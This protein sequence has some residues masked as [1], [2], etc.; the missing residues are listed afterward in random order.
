M[1]EVKSPATDGTQPSRGTGRDVA[2]FLL[3][4]ALAVVAFTGLPTGDAPVD[5]YGGR[6]DRIESTAPEARTNP[7]LS[8]PP[9]RAQR[10]RPARVSGAPVALEPATRT[11]TPC[12]AAVT[13]GAQP[14]NGKELLQHDRSG[15]GKLHI[16]NG[17]NYPGVGVLID[18]STRRPFRA[19]YVHASSTATMLRVNPG[20][21]RLQFALG[22]TWLE[23]EGRF[24]RTTGV[25]ELERPLE[26]AEV[27]R[28]DGILYDVIEVTFHK[29]EGGNAPT[30]DLPLEA[31]ALTLMG[32]DDG[33]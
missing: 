22:Q 11:P 1:E 33:E 19:M 23:G 20:T 28:P 5:A 9:V 21:Y 30:R 12:E 15:L 16:K 2:N 10:E 3:V 7:P 27:S 26:F 13:A 18:T 14:V 6:E 4:V 17:T 31:F 25:S 29:M 24:C 32:L 8:S